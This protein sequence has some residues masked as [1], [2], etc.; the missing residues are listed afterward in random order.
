MNYE[1]KIAEIITQVVSE[2]GIEVKV[3]Y[4]S[5]IMDFGL[6]SITIIKTIVYMEEEF[7]I[8]FDDEYLTTDAFKTI[9][10]IANYIRECEK[11]A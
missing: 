2:E 3:D 11:Q 10:D 5:D 9:R 6:N 7:E 1:E 4:D 8:E